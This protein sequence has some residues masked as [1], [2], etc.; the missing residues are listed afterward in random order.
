M[1]I[2]RLIVGGGLGNQLFQYA[3]YIYLLKRYP[4]SL[5]SLDFF[6]Y[7]YDAYHNGIEIHKIFCCDCLK[8]IIKTEMFRKKK[9]SAN[10]RIPTL[11]HIL[12]YKLQGFKTFYDND[13]NTPEKMDVIINENSSIIMA[14]FYQN[15]F[16][17]TSIEGFLRNHLLRYESL[18]IKNDALLASLTGVDTVSI[19]IRRGD[20]LTILQYDVFDGVSYYKR[21]ISHIQ[22]LFENPVFLVF[23]NDM[24][25]VKLNVP[26]NGKV[27]YVDWNKDEE[28]Y[29]DMILMSRCKH[30][31]ITNSSFSWWGAWLNDFPDKIVI[32]PK[33]WFRDK[34]ARD[35]VPQ[36]WVLM[37]N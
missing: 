27:I 9:K 23:S 3:T 33:Q 15:P 12:F 17:T 30:N 13:I 21:A 22:K 7:K 1:K 26:I 14:G 34:V 25:W 20:Y 29:K 5:I 37:E 35:V 24:E 11:L 36:S 10:K 18:G 31:I 19:H 32:A 6:Q 8:M 2:I 16:F 28:S 4:E